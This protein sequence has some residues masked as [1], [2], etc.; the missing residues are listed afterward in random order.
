MSTT[1]IFESLQ[2]STLWPKSGFLKEQTSGSGTKNKGTNKSSIYPYLR[3]HKG[4]AAGSR[5]TECRKTILQM[6][7]VQVANEKIV[8]ENIGELKEVLAEVQVT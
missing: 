8:K 2:S 3:V 6:I 7:G 5:Q 4:C 1:S